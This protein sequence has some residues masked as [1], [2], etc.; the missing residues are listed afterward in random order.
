MCWNCAKGYLPFLEPAIGMLGRRPC[1]KC[2]KMV[3]CAPPP[4]GQSY[5]LVPNEKIIAKDGKLP[6]DPDTENRGS[7]GYGFWQ[8]L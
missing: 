3:D 7:L 6:E 2:G 5:S 1:K 4:V 8:K